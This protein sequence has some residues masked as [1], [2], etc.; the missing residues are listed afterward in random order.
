MILRTLSLRTRIVIAMILLAL[1][2]A[3][4]LSYLTE[5]LLDRSLRL[6]IHPNVRSVLSEALSV[7]KTSYSDR[8]EALGRLGERLAQSEL[9]AEA[10]RSSD[11][12]QLQNLV[13]SDEGGDRISEV[14]V[15]RFSREDPSPES[16]LE[17]IPLTH[18]DLLKALRSGPYL[19]RDRDQ[20]NLLKIL[21]PFFDNERI[22]GVLSLVE[23]IDPTFF[24][25]EG[26]A[27]T[28][29][30]I[31]TSERAIRRAHLLTVLA[32]AF[33]VL[34]LAT[35]VGVWIAFGITHPLRDLI[36]GTR[37]LAR[38]NLSHRI[39]Q[40]RKDEIGLLIDSFNRMA[41]DLQE[42]RRQRVE[43]EKV[44]AWRE[45]ARRLAHE[46]KNPLTPIQLTVQEMRDKYGGADPIYK[47]LLDDCAE[48]ITEEVESLK[49]LVK[50]FADF[51]RL[52]DLKVTPT[53]LNNLI[54]DVARL[55]PDAPITLELRDPIPLIP[56][57]RGQIR[58]VLINLI[59]NAA[60]G[61]D[62]N[63][64]ILIKAETGEPLEG[65]YSGQG[66]PGGLPDPHAQG[67]IDVVVSDT[68]PG[69]P[70]ENLEHIFEPYFS[71]KRTG[72]GLGLAIVKH[73]V[74]QHHGQINVESHVGTG[75]SFTI[76]LPVDGNPA[77][78]NASG[79]SRESNGILRS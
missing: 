26:A 4:A 69:I 31:D 5:S 51:A 41:S 38:D 28:Y 60:V 29:E 48:I 17:G 78:G 54:E 22:A 8:R 43:A 10:F 34:L 70:P 24:R 49:N 72:M 16:G 55:Y 47:K 66:P 27:Q 40:H 63:G 23:Q 64:K 65:G 11:M 12:S 13:G 32:V 77:E 19:F 46:I 44:A 68:G 75:T 61:L 14:K 45:I 9:A 36:K 50:V 74:E 20:G 52:P 37:E 1:A 33:A 7:A 42:N 39:P 59:E 57:D 58:R 53:A 67:W 76:R 25:I 62:G 35:G 18:T 21:V 56:V 73:I 2:T 6:S 15:I 71:T 30:D 3:L 79:V